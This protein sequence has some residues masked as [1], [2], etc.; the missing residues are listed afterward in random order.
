MKSLLF[1]HGIHAS[2]GHRGDCYDNT[3]MESFFSTLKSE[4]VNGETFETES[5]ARRQICE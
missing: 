4:L 3:V 1:L 2:H 5:E